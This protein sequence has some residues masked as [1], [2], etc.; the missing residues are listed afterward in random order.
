MLSVQKLAFSY[1]REPVLDKV[2]FEMPSGQLC[3]LLGPNGSGKTTL[4]KCCLNHIKAYQGSVLIEGIETR[5]MPAKRMARAAAYVP[6]EHQPPFPFQVKDIVL[7]GRTPH[8]GAFSLVSR[9]DKQKTMEVLEDLGLVPLANRQYNQ[10]SGGQRQLVLLARA[11]A[12]ESP[13]MLLDEPTSALDLN[14]QIKIWRTIRRL[15]REG[16]T[17]LACSHD[18]NHLLWFCDR[19]VVL[20]DRQVLAQ[21]EPAATITETL[22]DRLYKGA[23]SVVDVAGAPMIVPRELMARHSRSG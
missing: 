1:G 8:L 14:N 2:S 21:G 13:V 15:S 23:C 17:V 16:R 18:P 10:L 20:H 4:F 9:R 6:Q 19:V 5:G 7:M 12:Q 3:G 22:L 11:M